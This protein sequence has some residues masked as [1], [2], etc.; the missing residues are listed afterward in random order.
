[1]VDGVVSKKSDNRLQ[2]CDLVEDAVSFMG[3]FFSIV[4]F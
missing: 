4:P 2:A 1:M 3:L